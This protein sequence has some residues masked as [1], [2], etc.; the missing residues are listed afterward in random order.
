MIPNTQPDVY[1][2]STF[3]PLVPGGKTPAI[4]EWRKTLPGVYP[5]T[6]SYGIALTDS[7]LVLDFDPRN[8]PEGRDMLQEFLAKFPQLDKTRV[9]KTP[10]GGVHIYFRK[11]AGINVKKEQAAWPGVDFLSAGHYVVGPG[12]MTVKGPKTVDGTYEL[13][14]DMPPIEAPAELLSSLD[15][16]SESGTTGSDEPS[17]LML[18]KFMAECETCQPAIEGQH[19]DG[20]TYRLACKGRDFGL[21]L[22]VV[23]EAMRDVFNPRCVPPWNEGELRQKVENAYTYAKN[24]PGSD[25]PEAKF[26]QLDNLLDEAQPA[27]QQS[28]TKK[29]KTNK[30][31]ASEEVL[32]LASDFELWHDSSNTAYATIFINGH[33]EHYAVNSEAFELLTTQHLFEK[34]GKVPSAQALKDGIR[35]FEAK[36]R[37]RG[38]GYEAGFRVAEHEGKIYI[39]LCNSDWQ[40]V[41]ISADGWQVVD[42]SPVRFVRSDKMQALPI[43][44]PAG[45]E[46]FGEL[47]QLLS[48]FSDDNSWM[49]FVSFLF[50]C[51]RPG[52]PYPVLVLSGEQGSAKSTLTREIRALIDPTPFADRNPPKNTEELMITASHNY[53]CSYDNLSRLPEWLSDTLCRLSTGG[54]IGGRKLYTDKQEIVYRAKRP[55]VINGIEDL[56]TRGDLLERS[57]VVSLSEIKDENRKTDDWLLPRLEALRPR[58][59]GAL[60]SAASAALKRLPDVQLQKMPRMA[61]FYTWVIAAGNSLGFTSAE[62]VEAFHANGCKA[63]DLTLDSSPV[64]QF[65][66]NDLSPVPWEGTAEQLLGLARSARHRDCQLFPKTPKT[67]SDHLTRLAPALRK[68]GIV[69]TKL[70]RT[71]SQRKIKIEREKRA[72]LEDLL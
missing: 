47:R 9:V 61:D 12:S 65:I 66:L 70:P 5:A 54:S 62:F 58:L 28:T 67:M 20:T 43:P 50:A 27:E 52:R 57:L 3:F 49:L 30:T 7:D 32:A 38:H 39:D 46:V 29:G 69:V 2:P 14:Y 8:Y 15:A 44:E 24:A 19:G 42:H 41:E 22:D 53:V 59:L 51:L 25:T 40:V 17:L 72:R 26:K 37:F 1:T 23:F 4:R 10:R 45:P 11:P 71:A 56:A 55:V 6:S 60:Y 13:Y 63:A 35:A 48:N 31:N 68:V 18:H 34:K 36:A 16:P 64:A 21:P 33:Y